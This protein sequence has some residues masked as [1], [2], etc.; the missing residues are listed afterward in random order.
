MLDCH[1][2]PRWQDT[3][4][5]D[6]K[7]MAVAKWLDTLTL[8][9][10]TRC[11][12]KRILKQLIDKAVYWELISDRQNPM[13]LVKVKGSTKG[14]KAITLLTFEQVNA[15]VA[16]LDLPVSLMVLTAA[17]LGLRISEAVALQWSDFD[18]VR[19]QVTIR[20]CLTR[21]EV[22]ATKTEASNADLPVSDV[23]RDALDAY[24]SGDSEWVFPSSATGGP[25]WG[26][27]IL[28]DYI[29][30]AVLRLGLPHPLSPSCQAAG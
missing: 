23:L 29:K 28:E 30:P 24:L 19:R 1:I 9:A 12:I 14:V 22:K 15:L 2:I 17:S 25:R 27:T 6:L 5:D 13:R 16:A 3:L 11:R 20:R 26:N 21:G 8:S 18:T 7:P 4:A 10:S